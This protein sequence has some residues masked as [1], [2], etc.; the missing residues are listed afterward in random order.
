MKHSQKFNFST[1]NNNYTVLAVEALDR[2]V[3]RVLRRVTG[4]SRSSRLYYY[5][6]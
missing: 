2:H 3:V 5:K 1:N 4:A 6:L